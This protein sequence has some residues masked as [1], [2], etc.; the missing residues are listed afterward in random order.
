MACLLQ[1][2][3]PHGGGREKGKGGKEV[4]GVEG[5]MGADFILHKTLLLQ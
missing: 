4:D 2:N 5:E 3:A 1:W